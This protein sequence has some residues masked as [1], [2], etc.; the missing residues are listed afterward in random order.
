MVENAEIF[1]TLTGKPLRAPLK[2]LLLQS[3]YWLARCTQFEPGWVDL[4]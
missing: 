4:S 2:P 3:S 1:K